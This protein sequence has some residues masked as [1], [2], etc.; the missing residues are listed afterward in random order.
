MCRCFTRFT[1]FV[2]TVKAIPIIS[3]KWPGC[4]L[5][6]LAKQLQPSQKLHLP[7]YGKRNKYQSGEVLGAALLYKWA[8]TTSRKLKLQPEFVALLVDLWALFR[9]CFHVFGSF[10]NLQR[11]YLKN[12]YVFPKSCVSWHLTSNCH[13]IFFLKNL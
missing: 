9:P 12:R 8:N 3:T 4:Y 7:H 2:K 13:T 5:Y 1:A 11:W 10:L 6:R